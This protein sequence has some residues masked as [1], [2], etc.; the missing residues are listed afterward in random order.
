MLTTWHC[1]HSITACC[2]C[3][4]RSIS[5]ACRANSSKPAAAGSV[6]PRS[7][8]QMDTIPF[9][10]PYSTYHAG[11]AE[12][13]KFAMWCECLPSVL[14]RCW[15]GGRK[16][17]RPVKTWV[18]GC[19]RDYLSGARCRLAQ[20]MPLP[21]TV[22]CFSKIQIG[23]AFLVPAHPGSP[24]QRAVRRVCVCVMWVYTSA[25]HLLCLFK[26][27]NIRLKFGNFCLLFVETLLQSSAPFSLNFQIRLKC[28][29]S[30]RENSA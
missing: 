28:Q 4:N 18:V 7:D 14:W 16:G 30:H 6:G 17:I 22:S 2:C 3:S 9:H 15:L 19:W 21:L 24:G 8:K 20:L 5:P 29:P 1:P 13:D 23:F 10:R 25:C 26:V 12:N 27:L 11:S